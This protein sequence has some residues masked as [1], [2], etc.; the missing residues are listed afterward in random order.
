LE[1]PFFD[2]AEVV[3]FDGWRE[4]GQTEVGI[5]EFKDT[6]ELLLDDVRELEGIA[7]CAQLF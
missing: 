2:G 4:R 1:G 3:F 5:S 6:I 7:T